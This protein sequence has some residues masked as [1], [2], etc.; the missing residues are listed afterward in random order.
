MKKSL[1]SKIREGDNV[2]TEWSA[3]SY[4]LWCRCRAQE[5]T[6]DP[7]LRIVDLYSVLHS[8][9]E[10]DFT[11]A[12]RDAAQLHWFNGMSVSAAAVELGTST[13]NIYKALARGKE[14]IRLVLKHIINSKEFT[15]EN[16]SF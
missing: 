2:Q 14:K 10:K 13:A 3:V 16:E 8:V 11:P 12:E 6:V 7:R 1:P 5:F 15:Y 4:D 9:I